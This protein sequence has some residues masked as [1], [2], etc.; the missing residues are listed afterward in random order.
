LPECSALKS[1]R[2]STPQDHGFTIDHEAAWQA[3]RG[4]LND[5]WEALSPIVAA[6]RNQANEGVVAL[7]QGDSRRI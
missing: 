7:K 4:G 2:T 3:F 6:L 5:P 1:E